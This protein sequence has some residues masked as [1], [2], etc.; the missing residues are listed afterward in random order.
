VGAV[1]SFKFTF[2]G[3]HV[4]SELEEPL[5]R[6]MAG[7]R[8]DEHNR[9]E[10]SGHNAALVNDNGLTHFL[11]RRFLIGGSPEHVA[12]RIREL[13]SWGASNL[14]LAAMWGDPIAY[15]RRIADEVMPLL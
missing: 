15:T 7:Y 3:K 8:S 14:L 9:I 10:S 6:L 4:P 1:S 12:A 13:R 2:E 5:R 11:G